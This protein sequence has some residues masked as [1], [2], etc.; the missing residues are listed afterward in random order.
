MIHNADLYM[1]LN[2]NG[3]YEFMQ[4]SIAPVFRVLALVGRYH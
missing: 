4:T 2:A 3:T 1:L